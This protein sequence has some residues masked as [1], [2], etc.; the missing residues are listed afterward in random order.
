MISQDI[1][2]LLCHG[3]RKKPQINNTKTQSHFAFF[4]ENVYKGMIMVVMMIM[5]IIIIL[6]SAI[7]TM[8]TLTSYQVIQIINHMYTCTLYIL[9]SFLETVPHYTAHYLHCG[10]ISDGLCVCI[11]VS[12]SFE[13]MVRSLYRKKKWDYIRSVCLCVCASV[14]LCVTFEFDCAHVHE[15]YRQIEWWDYIRWSGQSDGQR[16]FCA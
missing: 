10:T 11:H 6:M 12:V 4:H 16:A 5:M 14:C 13:L 8:S 3:N 9:H 1:D 7:L 15:L 2:F